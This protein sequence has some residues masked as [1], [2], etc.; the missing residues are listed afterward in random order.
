MTKTAMIFKES[1][2]PAVQE[3][4]RARDFFNSKYFNS[5]LSDIIITIQTKGR[6]SAL[7]WFGAN[8]WKNNKTEPLHEINI[9]AEHLKVDP[10][11]TLIHELV[12]AY[13]HVNKVKD[14]SGH[15]Y[16]NKHFKIEA[17]RVG[18]IVT[19]DNRVG[20]GITTTGSKLRGIIDLEF[21]LQDDAFNV[22]RQEIQ[23]NK[24]PTKMKKWV[25]Y[26]GVIVRCAVEL[27]AKCEDCN[28]LFEEVD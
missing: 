5:K 3:L 8:R 22:F 26:C 13:N 27:N 19:Y 18:L 14:C 15:Q 4:E 6:K 1:L 7:G 28:S 24:A 23:K 16:H 17:E 9:S 25:C 11:G 10:I 21:K 2:L 12:H 20:Y